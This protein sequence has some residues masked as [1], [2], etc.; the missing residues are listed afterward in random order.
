MNTSTTA[1]KEAAKKQYRKDYYEKNKAAALASQKAY[2]ERNPEKI[3][4]IQEAWRRANEGHTYETPSGYTKYIGYE[5]P[6]ST[7]SGITPYHRIVLWDKLSGQ[8]AP[9]HVCGNTVYWNLPF[10]E[11]WSLVADHL[12]WNPKNNAPEN[13]EPACQPCNTKRRD[14]S[15][16][17]NSG[18]CSV[19]NCDRN[20]K[21]KGL[22]ASH[23]SQ[24]WRG[25]PL[26]DLSANAHMTE[27]E[28]AQIIEALQAGERLVDVA[29][30]SGFNIGAISRMFEREVGVSLRQWKKAQ[31]PEE[32]TFEG[33]DR[34]KKTK[35]LCA[36]HYNQ[37]LHG[38]PLTP[39]RAK[40]ANGAGGAK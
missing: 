10:G 36:A 13:L 20:A 4:A 11:R 17:K 12:D 3:R 24:M 37:T 21:V 5:H 1:A 6:A 40:K 29:Q 35:G 23:Y 38:K 30:I 22:C 15:K 34:K 25:V 9:C 18:P 8:D 26:T 28:K 31:E 7:P 14:P 32:C 39:I 33:C 27:A 19:E 16:V 2:R